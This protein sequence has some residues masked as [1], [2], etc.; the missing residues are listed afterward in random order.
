MGVATEY[1]WV[2]RNEALNGHIKIVKIYKAWV[3]AIYGRTMKNAALSD[4]IEI[5]SVKNGGNRL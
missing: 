3:V 1:N 2:A 4:H 5:I